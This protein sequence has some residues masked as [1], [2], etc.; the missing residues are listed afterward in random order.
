MREYAWKPCMN[1]EFVLLTGEGIAIRLEVRKTP[2][3]RGGS[4]W[5][6]VMR[7]SHCVAASG[8]YLPTAAVA[9]K[10]AEVELEKLLEFCRKIRE[11]EVE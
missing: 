2:D 6:W 1:G 10:E 7:L 5:S 3:M 9:K 11:G 4:S 8:Y